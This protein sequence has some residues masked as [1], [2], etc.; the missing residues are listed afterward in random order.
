MCN[1]HAELTR[2]MDAAALSQLLAK[3]APA[4]LDGAG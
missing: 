1:I 3:T 4:I 2:R